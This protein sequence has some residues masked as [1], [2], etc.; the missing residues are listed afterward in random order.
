MRHRRQVA[1]E[2]NPQR[3]PPNGRSLYPGESLKVDNRLHLINVIQS[4]SF[5]QERGKR[6]F[7][8]SCSNRRR[9]VLDND[10][11]RLIS[12]IGSKE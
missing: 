6:T 11:K 1:T 8:M 3:G 2:Q 4:Y 10:C 7:F 5:H 9:E 12:P